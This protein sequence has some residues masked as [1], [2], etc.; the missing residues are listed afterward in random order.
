M[1]DIWRTRRCIWSLALVQYFLGIKVPTSFT[2]PLVPPHVLTEVL[3]SDH[4]TV[5]CPL[6]PHAF[7][8]QSSWGWDGGEGEKQQVSIHKKNALHPNFKSF[9]VNNKK[10]ANRSVWQLFDQIDENTPFVSNYNRRFGLDSGFC[11]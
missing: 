11:L 10:T 3:L 2:A 9:K 7:V 8:G 5:H 1:S 4:T 6:V